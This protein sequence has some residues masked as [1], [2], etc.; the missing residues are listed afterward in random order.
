[1]DPVFKATKSN[2]A[3]QSSAKQV[4]LTSVQDRTSNL[5]AMTLAFAAEKGLS[6]SMVPDLID[7][8]KVTLL[9]YGWIVNCYSVNPLPTDK[10]DAKF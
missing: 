1:M 9:F 7:Y 2:P 6:L 4:P 8:T 5:E 3:V 10:R